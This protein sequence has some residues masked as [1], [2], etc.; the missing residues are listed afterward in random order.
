M[1]VGIGGEA[2]IVTGTPLQCLDCSALVNSGNKDARCRNYP[3][4]IPAEKRKCLCLHHE[5]RLKS[6]KSYRI[7]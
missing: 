7:R 6:L 2:V 4:G 1:A 5:Y 3:D